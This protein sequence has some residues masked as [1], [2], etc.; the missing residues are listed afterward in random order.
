MNIIEI[1]SDFSGVSAYPNPFNPQTSIKF[2]LPESSQ[3]TVYV[4]DINGRIVSELVDGN[5]N[6]GYHTYIWNPQDISS[7]V[8]FVNIRTKWVLI[9][10]KLC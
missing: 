7:G 1:P 2:G 8:Y 5:L 9:L 6:A 10:R 3:V 4:Y